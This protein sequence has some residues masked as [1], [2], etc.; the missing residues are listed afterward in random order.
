MKTVLR[1]HANYDR[2]LAGLAAVSSLFDDEIE[3]R[4]RSIVDAVRDRGDSAVLEFVKT[5]D[6]VALTTRQLRAT[7][8]EIKRA[9]SALPPKLSFSLAEAQKNIEAFSRHSLRKDWARTNSQGGKVGEKFEGFQRVGIYV[10]GGTAPLVSTV[11]MTVT[12]AKVAGCSEI[13]VCTP[14]GESGRIN[15]AILATAHLAGATEIYKIGGA[16]AIAAMAH[17]TKTIRRVDKIFGPGNAYVV[18]AKRLLF[19]HVALDLLPG[20]S[21]ILVLAD[22]TAPAKFVAADLLAQAEQG[23]GHERTWLIS[24]SAKVIAAVAAEM[25]RQ[26]PTLARRQ[27]IET[28]LQNNGWL[29]QARNINHAVE[30]TNRLAPEHCQIVARSPNSIAKQIKTAGAIFIG[31]FS[32]TVIGDYIAGPSHVL[33]TGGAGRSFS[34]LTIDQFQRRT[35]LV[36]YTRSALKQSLRSLETLAEVEGLSAHAQS[37]KVRFE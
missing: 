35:S 10:P 19:G 34:G 15:D 22:D 16:Q 20:P 36:S 6:R 4:T 8:E 3:R 25:Q 13:V 21:E 26:L 18:M 28:A 5:F 12:L 33:P 17:G 2:E 31:P 30:L 1:S 23:S 37:A 27:F 11:L 29:I 9:T 24:P 7:A 32:P 14:C